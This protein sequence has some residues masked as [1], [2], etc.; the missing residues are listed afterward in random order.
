MTGVSRTDRPAPASIS[1]S[2]ALRAENG[3]SMR[4]SVPVASRSKATKDAGVFSASSRTRDCAGWMRC[5]NASKSSDWPLISTISPSTTHLG[6][7][8]CRMAST[9]SGK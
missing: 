2:R 9:S 5:C 1:S 4:S 3:A 6:G 7:S 8:S